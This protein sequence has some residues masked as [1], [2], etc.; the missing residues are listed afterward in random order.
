MDLASGIKPNLTQSL[1]DLDPDRPSEF[2]NIENLSM[3]YFKRI[4][5]PL[6]PKHYPTETLDHQYKNGLPFEAQVLSLNY[7]LFS[8]AGHLEFRKEAN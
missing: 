8:Q 2:F 7:I 5:N 3:I 4:S 6:A 1:V